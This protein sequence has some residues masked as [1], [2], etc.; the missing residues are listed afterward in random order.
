MCLQP[1]SQETYQ[2]RMFQITN[3][4]SHLI[5]NHGF[6]NTILFSIWNVSLWR[7]KG[8]QRQI[9]PLLPPKQI[10]YQKTG[11]IRARDRPAQISK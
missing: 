2:Q 1:F 8:S 7:K 4:K 11:L 3:G 5:N 10:K 6:Y 9:L